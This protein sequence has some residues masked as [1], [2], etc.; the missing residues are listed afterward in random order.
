M[1]TYSSYT[2]SGEEVIGRGPIHE[3]DPRIEEHPE[4]YLLFIYWMLPLF[5]LYMILLH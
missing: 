1:S 4:R 2:L 5:G 3:S